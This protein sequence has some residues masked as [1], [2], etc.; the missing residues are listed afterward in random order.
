MAP[1][2]S[3][4]YPG[5]YVQT[6]INAQPPTSGVATSVA[7]FIGRAPQGPVNQPVT[8]LSLA[9]YQRTFGGLDA[10]SS[11]SYQVSAFFNNGGAQAQVVRLY[12]AP[13]ATVTAKLAGTPAAGTYSVTFAPLV[14]GPTIEVSA[15]VPASP[16]PTAQIVYQALAEALEI[17]PALAGLVSSVTA[18]ATSLSFQLAYASTVSGGGGTWTFALGGGNPSSEV[19]TPTGSALLQFITGTSFTLAD[20]PAPTPTQSSKAVVSLST[21]SGERVLIT[22]TNSTTAVV[23]AANLATALFTMIMQSAQARQL[24]SVVRP[25]GAT[26]VF[27]YVSPAIITITQTGTTGPLPGHNVQGPLQLS[28]ANPGSWGDDLTASVDVNGITQTVA[29]MYGLQRTDLFNLTVIYAG[30]ASA[31]T[32]RFTAVT[33]KGNG[34]N[35]LDKVLANQSSLVVLSDTSLLGSAAPANGSWGAGSGGVDSAPL[36]VNDYTGDPASGTGLYAFNQNPYSFNILCIPPDNTTQPDLEETDVAV[37]QE[38]AQ[39]CV[40]NNAMLIIDPPVSWYQAYQQGNIESIALSDLGN[41][42]AE[43]ARACAVYFPRV[44]IADP[45][46]NGL[47]KT[48]VPSGYVAAVWASTD[49]A[50]GVWKAPAGLDAPI[51]GIIGLQ[52]NLNNAQNGLLN[53][54]GINAL[55]FFTAGGNVVWGAR[56]LRGADQLADEYKYVPVQRLL[57]YIANSLRENTRWAVFQ[58]NGEALWASLTTQVTQ[59]M[60]GLFSQGAFS[61]TSASQAFFVNCNATTTTAADQ[62]AGIVNLQVGFAPI[63]PAEFVVIT[64]SQQT[65]SSS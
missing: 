54:E 35:R 28:A 65:A 32:E 25:S 46:S 45:L 26:L 33:L 58:P 53:P 12:R 9:D 49:S 2:V 61:G 39:V 57:N 10:G 24:L 34:P 21:P 3:P 48:V 6:V 60:S 19:A 13:L 64:I 11:L 42:T 14:S 43:Q 41:Y 31:L 59:F 5:V 37:Y 17:E 56:T 40:D 27:N 47:P 15:S 63:Y 44:V 62:A 50:V 4:T 22:Y 20:L 52:A 55:R 51:G 8:L 36:Q 18:S 1:S 7:A 29:D 38:A 23:S 30:G 16:A